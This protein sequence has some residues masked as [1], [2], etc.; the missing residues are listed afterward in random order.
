ME[1]IKGL[2]INPDNKT[3]SAAKI[4]TNLL[5]KDCQVDFISTADR[6]T[7]DKMST[8]A[9]KNTQEKFKSNI[10]LVGN[11]TVTTL[12]TDGADKVLVDDKAQISDFW[13][14]GTQTNS[15]ALNNQN[16]AWVTGTQIGIKKDGK[17]LPKELGG[18]PYQISYKDN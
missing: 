7:S 14:F 5:L 15:D 4:Q 12:I 10:G 18:M 6:D 9:S 17:Y 1:N 13:G 8:L 3:R 16:Y 11:T 2:E